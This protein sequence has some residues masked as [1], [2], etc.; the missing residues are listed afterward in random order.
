MVKVILFNSIIIKEK[1]NKAAD[2]FSI[3]KKIGVE[4]SI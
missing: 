4:I 1:K 2:S 3:I